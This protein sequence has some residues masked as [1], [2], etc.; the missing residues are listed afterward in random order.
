MNT[1]EALQ[2]LK[3]GKKIKI[4]RDKDLEYSQKVYDGYLYLDDN[5]MIRVSWT[6]SEYWDISVGGCYSF[7]NNDLYEIYKEPILT[8]KEKKYLDNIIKPLKNKIVYIKKG[9]IDCGDDDNFEYITIRIESVYKYIGGEA[10][11]LPYFKKG[12]HYKGMEINRRYSL[13][14]LGL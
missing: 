3:E 1:L 13:K 6:N 10:I 12:E 11:S 7:F 14:E 2:A 9:N 4:L 5:G 8:D